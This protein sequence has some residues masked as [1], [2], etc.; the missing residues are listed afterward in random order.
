MIQPKIK[1]G[2]EDEDDD[3][4]VHTIIEPGERGL[5][6]ACQ[7]TRALIRRS[8][9]VSRVE[10]VGR[11]A[12]EY[13]NRREA[14]AASSNRPFY[15]KQ[16]VQTIRRYAEK[17][18][19]ILRYIWRTYAVDERPPY[20]LTSQQQH[21]LAEFQQLAEAAAEAQEDSEARP[22]EPRSSYRRPKDR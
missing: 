22:T 12:M 20:R 14:G 19:K 4:A 9:Q 7:A 11:A 21:A 6:S 1:K 13:V 17:F 3:P 5:E 18:V 10:I 16:K 8:F 15:G 2:E